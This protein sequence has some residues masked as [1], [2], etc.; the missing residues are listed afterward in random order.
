MFWSRAVVTSL[1]FALVGLPVC[2]EETRHS[3][4]TPEPRPDAWWQDLHRKFN[5]RA[6]Q[7]DV[8]LV[9]LGDSI[10]QG[11]NDNPVW[12]RHFAPRKAANFG[13]S[14]D[15]TQHVLW[16]IENGNLEGISPKLAVLMIGT[17]NAAANSAEE[18]ADGITQ[19]VAQLREKLP[20]TKV[21]LLAIFPRGE[22][23][24]DMR[25]KL[26]QASR[27]ASE[28]ADGDM[29]RFV[30]IGPNFLR[31]DGTISKEVMPDFLHLSPRGY[32]IWAESIEPTVAEMLGET[33][34]N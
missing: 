3:A 21:L 15:R 27:L 6:K 8:E 10:T 25:D 24:N 16:R 2:A 11:W 4:V 33:K 7:G 1:A 26:A 14:G 20:R 34:A 19:I 28:V 13:I 12:K 18:I 32:E 17:N 30:D 29:V 9:F 5:E 22:A 31:E 23:P